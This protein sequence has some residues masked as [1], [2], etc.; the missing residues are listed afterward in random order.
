MNAGRR[1]RRRH[2][3]ADQQRARNLPERHAER[4][5]DQL[6]GKA[7]RGE[8]QEEGRIGEQRLKDDALPLSQVREMPNREL[9]RKRN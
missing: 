3:H 6:R 2:A 4:A 1:R 5:V 7:D 8:G 9:V